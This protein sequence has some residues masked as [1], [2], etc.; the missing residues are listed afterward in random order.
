[1]IGLL[2]RREWG[3]AFKTP[4]GWSL[5]ALSQLVLAWV[6]LR[7]LDRFTGV[8]AAGGGAGL[9]LE[10]THNLCGTAVVLMLLAGPLLAARSLSGEW[11]EGTFELIGASPV[12]AHQLLLG[13]LIGLAGLMLLVALL[14]LGLA[15]TLIGAAPVDLGMMAAAIL[16]LWLSC[17]LFAAAGL[18]AATLTGQPA[19]AA[20]IAYALLVGLSQLG[21]A[22]ALVGGSVS[23]LDW[24]SWSQ[25]LFWFL[26]GVVRVG[27]LA[28]FGLMTGL[29]LALAQRF[30]VN[31]R[32]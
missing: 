11:R 28:Y 17:L 32:L 9:N 20:L 6:F 5:L 10:L 22:D 2:A 21:R 25:H 12:A 26:A 18:F 3:L 16:G 19:L 30:L 24:L 13:K 8:G 23:W 29:F 4:L 15:A 14:P 1:M 27:D 7:V 31:R